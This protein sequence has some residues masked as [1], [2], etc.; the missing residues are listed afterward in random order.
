MRQ[1]WLKIC[2]V[3]LEWPRIHCPS[4]CGIKLR[5][6]LRLTDPLLNLLPFAYRGNRFVDDAVNMT[7]HFIPLHLDSS[8][9]CGRISSAINTITLALL[10][11][12]LSELSVPHLQVDHSRGHLGKHDSWTIS[13]GSPQ[14]CVLSPLFFSPYTNSCNS[15]HQSIK[16]L[17]SA[18]DTTFNGLISGGDDLPPAHRWPG[19]VRFT[20]WWP[21]TVRTIWSSTLYTAV[22]DF[23][24]TSSITAW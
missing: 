18:D 1:S 4:L 13:T 6:H 3:S 21:G 8:W 14:G 22:I 15:S 5:E 7:L 16:L 11:D 9:T 10:R 17:K 2:K 19:T 12:K 20:I 24:L 23:T